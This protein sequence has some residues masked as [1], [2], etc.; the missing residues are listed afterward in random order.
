MCKPKVIVICGPTASGKT[1]LPIEKDKKIN[2]KFFRDEAKAYGLTKEEIEECKKSGI[3]PEERV[4]IKINNVKF[5][6]N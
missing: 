6:G 3:T 5:I 4:K 2:E 1:N